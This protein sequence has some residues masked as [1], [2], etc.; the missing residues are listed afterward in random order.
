MIEILVADDEISMRRR[1][2]GGSNA[3]RCGQ[4]DAAAFNNVNPLL[5]GADLDANVVRILRAMC[6][7]IEGG[8][9]FRITARLVHGAV[10]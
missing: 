4:Q 7:R 5:G 2:V 10:A 9:E 6:W 3:A 1:R 8:G